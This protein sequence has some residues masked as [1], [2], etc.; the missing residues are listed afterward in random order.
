MVTGRESYT[1]AGGSVN[2]YNHSEHWCGGVLKNPKGRTSIWL[3][4]TAPG[5]IRLLKSVATHS[6]IPAYPCLLKH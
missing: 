5:Y 3:G 6:R 2:C 1:S 4:Y